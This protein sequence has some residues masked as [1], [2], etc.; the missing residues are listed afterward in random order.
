ML[1]YEDLIS[2]LK[3]RSL[4]EKRSILEFLNQSINEEI[5]STPAR[6][7]TSADELLG[8]A[9]PD[10]PLPSDEELEKMRFNDLSEKYP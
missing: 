8:I 2:E 4:E 3:Q 1:E 7:G 6:R 10:G 9:K 5:I